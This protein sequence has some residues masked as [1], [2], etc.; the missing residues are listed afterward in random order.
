MG[1]YAGRLAGRRL[2]QG[3]FA[4]WP[5]RRMTRL[6][7]ATSGPR[8][9]SDAV[10]WVD[11]F[12]SLGTPAALVLSP[13]PPAR[14]PAHPLWSAR[15]FFEATVS[16]SG[17]FLRDATAGA[18]ACTRA[19]GDAKLG[20]SCKFFDEQLFGAAS[21]A[22]DRHFPCGHATKPS[23]HRTRAVGTLEWF[24]KIFRVP[25]VSGG[26][27]GAPKKSFRVPGFSGG[28]GRDRKKFR[29]QRSHTRPRKIPPTDARAPAGPLLP[30]GL[31]LPAGLLR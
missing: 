25:G 11:T 30:V 9:C 7:P 3:R 21:T 14:P 6:S 5:T 12:Q 8:R 19:V 13:H 27:G 16:M 20:R 4:V 22:T 2:P 31:L 15:E 28:G 1:C 17:N 24:E 23:R 10:P 29:V 26:G 18:E